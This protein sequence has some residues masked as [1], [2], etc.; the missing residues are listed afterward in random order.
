MRASPVGPGLSFDGAATQH[1]ALDAYVLQDPTGHSCG[2]IIRVSASLQGVAQ[3]VAANLG[4]AIGSQP[5]LA[6]AVPG[7]AAAP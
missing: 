7:D 5:A 2:I 6:A 1:M 3:V 4:A